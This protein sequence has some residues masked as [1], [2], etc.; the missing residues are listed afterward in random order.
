MDDIYFRKVMTVVILIVLLV[1]SF[2]LLKPILMALITG[3]ILAFIFSPIYCRLNAKIKSNNLSATIMCV[4][5]ILL[6]VLPIFFLAPV[7]LNQAGKIFSSVQDINFVEII[8]EIFP[9]LF[10]VTSSGEI[11]SI[12]QSFINDSTSNLLSSISKFILNLPLLFLQSLVVFFTFF[13][14]LRDSDKMASYVKSLSPFSKEIEKKLFD[15]S[16]AITSSVIYGQVV[17]GIIQ[18]IITG[19]GFFIFG[20]SNALLLTLLACLAG[21]FPIIGTTIVWIPVAIYLFIEGNTG[22]AIGVLI[23]GSI[24]S[25]IDNFL[26]PIIVS[27]RAKMNSLLI[28]LGMIGGLFL[29]G[30]LGFILGPLIL[31]YLIIILDLYRNKK[32]SNILIEEL[33]NECFR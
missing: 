19:L 14:V 28:L 21:I 31:A 26:R 10:S 9:S 6:I 33:P 18:G 1:L 24:S 32:V 22:A 11:G 15:S 7:V 27:K 16:K 5:L 23:F 12:I 4:L 2:F 20:V 8:K 13:F 25:T 30:I 17:I 3:L 29:F